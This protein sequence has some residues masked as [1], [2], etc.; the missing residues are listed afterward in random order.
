MSRICADLEIGNIIK[1]EKK[2]DLEMPLPRGPDA[3]PSPGGMAI[4]LGST[5]F[6]NV[7]FGRMVS[8]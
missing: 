5:H 4:V 6:I 3:V 1:C 2:H 7:E 8:G